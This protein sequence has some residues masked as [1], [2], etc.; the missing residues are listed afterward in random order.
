MNVW[1]KSV[2]WNMWG[3]LSLSDLVIDNILFTSSCLQMILDIFDSAPNHTVPS[4]I[5]RC[6]HSLYTIHTRTIHLV[7]K[8]QNDFAVTKRNPRLDGNYICICICYVIPIFLI[9]MKIWVSLPTH[10]GIL[11]ILIDNCFFVIK[12][13]KLKIL[14]SIGWRTLFG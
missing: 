10:N 7:S 2:K 8:P 13:R 4:Q 12:Q 14:E 6:K 1:F 11:I 3:N 9:L 5:Y